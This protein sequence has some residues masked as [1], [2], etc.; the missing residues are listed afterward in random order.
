MSVIINNSKGMQIL[1]P[2]HYYTPEVFDP[3]RE[4]DETDTGEVWYWNH[5]DEFY[6]RIGKDFYTRTLKPSGGHVDDLGNRYV[7]CIKKN[8]ESIGELIFERIGEL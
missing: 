2:G 3:V 8:F 5:R 1:T 4:I 6:I 7:L